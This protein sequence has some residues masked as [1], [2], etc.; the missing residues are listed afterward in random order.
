MHA[1]GSRVKMENSQDLAVEMKSPVLEIMN[2]NY[3]R[4]HELTQDV[5]IRAPARCASGQ[6]ASHGATC[7]RNGVAPADANQHDDV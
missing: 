5:E 1:Y 6:N 7:C 4:P 2:M 3:S